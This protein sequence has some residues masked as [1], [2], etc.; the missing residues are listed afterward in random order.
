MKAPWPSPP[1]EHQ[2]PT[3]AR[4]DLT[5]AALM[6][7]GII[8]SQPISEPSESG[9]STSE[10]NQTKG[11]GLRVEVLERTVY[12]IRNVFMTSAV[13]RNKSEWFTSACGAAVCSGTPPPIRTEKRSKQTG[14]TDGSSANSPPPPPLQV[15]RPKAS[16]WQR[17][18]T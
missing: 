15:R 13:V 18:G 6:C 17:A 7:I 5:E 8:Q 11:E 14:K 9:R 12:S 1:K 16:H 2:S 3:S 4:F 10:I